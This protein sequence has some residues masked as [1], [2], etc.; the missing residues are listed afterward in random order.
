M[1]KPRMTL[2]TPYDSPGTL[3]FLVADHSTEVDFYFKKQKSLF[4][5]PFWGDVRTPSIA[6][7]KAR[8]RLPVHHN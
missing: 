6:R 4:E 3:V 2:T 1:V 7:W 8:D 5:P